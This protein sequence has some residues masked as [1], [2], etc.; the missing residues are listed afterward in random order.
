MAAAAA[1]EGRFVDIRDWTPTHR[2]AIVDDHGR[3]SGL[4]ATRSTP[5]SRGPK[6][7]LKRVDEPVRRVPVLRLGA[8]ARWDLPV[9]ADP[10]RGR[11]FGALEPLDSA[12][13]RSRTTA[14]GV[15]AADLRRHL[16][17][18]LH[19]DRS[20]PVELPPPL[21][22]IARGEAQSTWPLRGAA[23]REKCPIRDRP[24][25]KPGC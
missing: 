5:T 24:R 8:G 12:V 17:F 9:N 18:E 10:R 23:G 25:I 15:V 3:V 20:V 1:I 11:N 21:C 13:V 7:F 6:Q 4:S 22:A 19:E 2:R 16:R 14:S